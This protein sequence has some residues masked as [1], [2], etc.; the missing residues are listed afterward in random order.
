MAGGI[1]HFSSDWQF[2]GFWHPGVH[3]PLQGG[4]VGKYLQFTG[5]KQKFP[6][7]HI[8]GSSLHPSKV[9]GGFGVSG[10]QIPLQEGG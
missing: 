2:S 7:E 8:D 1:S 3:T 4:A 5:T 6:R 9:V 10:V